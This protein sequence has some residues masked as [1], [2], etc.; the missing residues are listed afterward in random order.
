MK[1]K[2]HEY[3]ER[4]KNQVNPDEPLKSE[5]ILKTCNPWNLRLEFN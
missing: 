2:K 5:L 1:L 4:K 3:N